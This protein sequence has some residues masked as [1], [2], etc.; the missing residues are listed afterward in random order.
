MSTRKR[1][2][3]RKRAARKTRA[4][5]RSAKKK[6]AAKS[7]IT[8][9]FGGSGTSLES[10]LVEPLAELEKILDHL[11]RRMW[12]R[13][14]GWD[15]P[16]LRSLFETRA[17][18]VDVVDRAEEITVTVEIPGIDKDDL[19][20]SVTDRILTIKGENRHEEETDEGDTHRREIHR[21]SFYR[22][23][24]LPTEIDGSKVKAECKNGILKLILPKLRGMKTHNI[25][26]R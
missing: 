23:L 25:E 8:A 22:T 13:P 9:S 6:S 18:C 5:K 7:A 21:G 26:L 16:D 2:R 17:P 20:V 4:E 24:T 11:R 12:F 3:A 10:R 14:S 15:W 1:R 19:Q